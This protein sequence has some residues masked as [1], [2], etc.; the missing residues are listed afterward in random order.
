MLMSLQVNYV[1]SL[2]RF[3]QVFALLEDL[4]LDLKINILFTKRNYG[5]QTEIFEYKQYSS[6]DSTKA[7]SSDCSSEPLLPQYSLLCCTGYLNTHLHILCFIPLTETVWQTAQSEVALLD[8]RDFPNIDVQGTI[9]GMKCSNE[10]QLI[11]ANVRP[12]AHISDEED[13]LYAS[14]DENS[15]IHNDVMS[16]IF[17]CFFFSVES[18]IS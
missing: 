1:Y 8:Y 10:S 4:K 5:H 15:D 12:F 7:C 2:N 18:F 11:I 6:M 17:L 9:I 16:T 3:K 14:S 13:M